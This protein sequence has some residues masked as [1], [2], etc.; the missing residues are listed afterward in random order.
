MLPRSLDGDN[1]T[2]E[3]YYDTVLGITWLADANYS[4]T[5][6]H[7]A[8]GLMDWDTAM[9]WVSSLNPYGSDITDWRMPTVTDTGTYGCNYARSGTDCGF[10]VDTATGEMASMFYD[11]LDNLA[12]YD[13]SASDT[14]QE[15]WGLSNTGPFSNLQPFNYW[16]STPHTPTMSYA[17]FFSFNVGQQYYSNKSIGRHA[18][19]VHDGD[20]GAP[21]IPIPGAVW[22]FGSGLIGLIGLARRKANA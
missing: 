7:D 10:N 21:I 22:L 15:G 1:T 9:G 11:T 18:W 16:S 12:F 6:G 2:A 20:V 4:M 5:T 13:T 19:A 8:D 14:P 17:W 3:A